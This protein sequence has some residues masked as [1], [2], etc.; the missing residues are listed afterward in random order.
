LAKI[1]VVAVLAIAAFTAGCAPTGPTPAQ[2][3][4]RAAFQD[5]MKACQ[6]KPV[7]HTAR[8]RCSNEVENH[9]LRPHNPNGD[10][11]DVLQ[12]T[13]L[14]LAEKVDENQMSL[15]DAQL[16]FAKTRAELVSIEKTRTNQE[17][18]LQIQETSAIL[19][20]MPVTCTA[21][22]ATATCY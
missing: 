13:R 16:E 4:E 21:F 9:Y 6:E 3:A 22:G 17:R 2:L 5:E 18:M 14:S 7:T 15:T 11:L 8:A 10:L 19:S 12:T 1:N 20:S